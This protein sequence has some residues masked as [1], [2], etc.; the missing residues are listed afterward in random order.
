MT[1]C[2]RSDIFVSQEGLVEEFLSVLKIRGSKVCFRVN[3][4]SFNAIKICQVWDFVEKTCWKRVN[5]LKILGHHMVKNGTFGTIIPSRHA[6]HE[7]LSVKRI[8]TD[9]VQHFRKSE[10]GIWNVKVRTWS[11]YGEIFSLCNASD[12]WYTQLLT[13]LP[14]GW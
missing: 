10:V 6:I 1:Q 14:D 5:F 3:V 9:N 11:K 8:N 2:A 4:T 13:S 7:I 12:C